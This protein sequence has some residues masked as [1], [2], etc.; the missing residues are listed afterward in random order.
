MLIGRFGGDE[1]LIFVKHT[2][3]DELCALA[4][5][6]NTKISCIDV[7][8]AKHI[9]GSIGGILTKDI[10]SNYNRLLQTADEALYEVKT[11]GKN[12]YNIKTSLSV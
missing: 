6:I 9:S 11:S 7:G 1:F 10:I 5:D 2:N 12:N 8:K 3:Y 4:R